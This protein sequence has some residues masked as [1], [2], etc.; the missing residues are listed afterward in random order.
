[1]NVHLLKS[2][3][4]IFRRQLARTYRLIFVAAMRGRVFF[5]LLYRKA[6]I[7]PIFLLAQAIAFK[8]L[9]SVVPFMVLLT[10][11]LG[12]WLA[13]EDAFT[14]VEQ[15]VVHLL[16]TYV[17]ERVLDYT[18]Q[19][20]LSAGVFT[21]AGGIGLF[22]S[23]LTLM[24]T[25]RQA[26]TLL[27]NEQYHQERSIVRG[28]L[29]D[30][31]MVLQVGILFIFTLLLNVTLQWIDLKGFSWLLEHATSAGWVESVRYL[32][33]SIMT[34]FIPLFISVLIFAQL[35]YLV[36]IPHPSMRAVGLGALFTALLWIF[37]NYVFTTYAL[38]LTQFD[39]T[40]TFGLILAF[41]LWVYVSG[42]IFCYGALMVLVVDTLGRQKRQSSPDEVS[43]RATVGD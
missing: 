27:F 38:N 12:Q 7:T 37:S 28:Y 4:P 21:L 33:M 19:V 39:L 9:L 5:R 11:L 17:A 14:V 2:A 1:M 23:A 10:G 42:L 32:L 8:V 16:P 43:D 26:L 15:F 30:F 29:F 25:L 35:F 18:R 36:P 6:L 13:Q 40:S 20:A 3:L 22:L 24:T 34:P 41:V 31:R